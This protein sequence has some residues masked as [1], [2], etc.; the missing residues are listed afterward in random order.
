MNDTWGWA[1]S[2]CPDV[3]P[4]QLPEVARLF[5]SYGR[6]GLLYWHSCQE[7][8]M[9]SEFHDNNRAI[10]FVRHEEEIRK[11]TPNSNARAYK[12]VS[13]VLGLPDKDQP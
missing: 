10:D 13:Y 11:E 3:T 7:K 9:R 5:R 12:V 8:D 1:L 4:E 2:W 6:A